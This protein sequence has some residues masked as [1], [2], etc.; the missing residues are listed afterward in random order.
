MTANAP[1]RTTRGDG[2]DAS[3]GHAVREVLSTFVPRLAVELAANGVPNCTSV[4]GSMLSADISGFTALSEKLAGKGKAGAEEI[5]ELVNKCF[6]ALIDAAYEYGG[7]VLKFG[8]DAVLVL[9]RGANHGRRAVDAGLSM[10]QALHSASAA[11]RANL[12]MTVGVAEGPFDVYLV[13]S[14]YREL[15]VTGARATEVIRLEGEAGK[16]DT[17]VSRALAALLPAAMRVREESGGVVVTGRTSDPPSGP[18]ARPPD[19]ADLAPFVPAAVRQQLAGFT[20]L[21]GEHRLVTVGFLMVV[22][23]D[24]VHDD[25]G[26]AGVADAFHD[27]VDDVIEACATFGVTVLHT[28]IAPDGVKFVLCAGAPVTPGDTGDAMLQAA[29][30]IAGIDSPFVL[31]QG[32]QTGRVFAGFLGSDFRRTYTLMGDPVNTAARMLGKAGDREIVAVAHVVDDTRTLFVTEPLEPFLVKGKS[33]PITAHRVVASSD[34]VRRDHSATRLFGRSR[35]LEIVSRSIGELGEVIV[36]NGPAGVGKSRLLDAAWDHAEGLQIF[37][38]SCTPYGAA[39]PYSVFR[40]LLRA[41][42]GIDLHTDPAAAGALLTEVVERTAPDLLPMIPLLAVPFGATVPDTPESGAIDP[43]FRR[44]RIHD[45]VIDF[46]DRTLDGPVFLVVEDLHWIDDA[47]GELLNHLMRASAERSWTGV[48]TRRPE[49]SW[50]IPEDLDHVREL[51]VE[52]LTDDAIRV[53]AIEVSERAL[54]DHDLDTVVRRS[55]GNPLFAIELTRAISRR[56]TTALPDSIEEMIAARIDSLPPAQRRLLRIASVFGPEF[57]L[58]QVAAIGSVPVEIDDSL[59]ELIEHTGGDTYHFVHAMYRDVAYEGLPFRHRQRLHGAVAQVIRDSAEDVDDVA[60]LLSLH[61]SESRLRLEAWRFSRMAGARAIAQHATREAAIA[62]ERAVGAARHC[63]EVSTV[64]RAGALEELG[65]QYY[66]LGQFDDAVRCYSGARRIVV[67]AVDRVTLTRKL[68]LA[69]ERKGQPIRA[70]RW[71]QRARAGVPR[72]TR[73]K[74]WLAARSEI[75]LAEAGLRSRRGENERSLELS[76]SALIDANRSGEATSRALALERVHLALVYLRRS[77]SVEVGQV[78]IEAHRRNDDAT[79]MARTLTNIGIEH[80]FAD[81]WADASASY[82]QALEIAERAGSIVPAATAAINSAEILS[83]QGHW[84]RAIELLENAIRNYESVGYSPGIAAANLFS[85]VAA[86]RA[87]QLERAADQLSRARELLEQQGMVEHLDE[88]DSRQVELELRDGT[89]TVE[90]CVAL[91]GRLGRDH[92]LTTRV[93][94]SVGLA[95]FI[96]ADAPEAMKVLADVAESAEPGSF[97][98]AMTLHALGL[99]SPGHDD[100]AIWSGETAEICARLGIETL[101]PLLRAD[102]RLSAGR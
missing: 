12:T 79:G 40:P 25:R 73:S 48:L 37:Q 16:G 32:I 59:A 36:L 49:G 94:R 88:V 5:T 46:L 61:Y 45:A 93:S 82:L 75:D 26:V 63:Q 30:R 65:D 53:L 44:A 50:Q 2:A 10:Q 9:F 77:E 11:K 34:E 21:G 14:G 38:G 97:E 31:R 85:A 18:A 67:E 71:Y 4:E 70:I 84:G 13:G 43:K 24:A 47:S 29:L 72:A 87:G 7:E 92:P 64:D 101:P 90:K 17:L 83:D 80:Y 58:G 98:R 19:D 20:G 68:G 27:L 41:G 56:S 57:D 96:E 39:S 23:V 8:G 74:P 52:P 60:S 99:V 91:I 54:S 33:E 51:L 42:S 6:T 22:G 55:S 3:G 66:E 15:L 102:S 69:F 62:L 1:A 100:A 86:T 78:A 81:R 28:D 95:L 76:Q 89:A 35:E